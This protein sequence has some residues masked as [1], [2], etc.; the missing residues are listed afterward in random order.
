MQCLLSSD[1]RQMASTPVIRIDLALP[2]PVYRQI[3]NAV[4]AQLVSGAFKPGDQ[5][6]T[7]RQLAMDL[8]VHHN[9]IAE[10]YRL[11]CDEGWLDMRRRHGVTVLERV[12]PKPSPKTHES[13]AVRL[14]EL[15][16]QASADGLPPATIANALRSLAQRLLTGIPEKE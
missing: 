11:L 7:V 16:A 3:A 8:G 9:T 14:E 2:T 10:A 13:F 5:L 6:P 12:Q 4:R 1:I 15:A